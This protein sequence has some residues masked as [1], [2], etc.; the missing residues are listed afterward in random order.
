[1]SQKTA[2][3]IIFDGVEELEAIAPIDILRRAEVEVSVAAV[4]PRKR[5][6]G[7]NQIVIEADR[8]LQEV[9][10]LDVDLVVLPGGPGHK[11]LLE[12]QSVLDLLQSQQG[13]GGL[14]GSICAGPVVLKRAGLLEG[15]RFTSF[16]ATAEH[17]P[18]REPEAPVVV[19]GTLITSQ[20]AGTAVPFALALV[21][22]LMGKSTAEAV[23]EE[24]CFP[25]Q[26]G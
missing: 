20:G 10:E 24:I 25:P 9:A 21:A 16:P 7:R 3:V 26:L 12:D 8:H 15:R 11:T 18:D 14:V 17:L 19:D 6:T 22:E 5:V 1:M 13:K 23:A 2:L 4:G